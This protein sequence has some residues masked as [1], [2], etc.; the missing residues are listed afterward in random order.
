MVRIFKEFLNFQIIESGMTIGFTCFEQLPLYSAKVAHTCLFRIRDS[1]EANIWLRSQAL[2]FAK[3]CS[4]QISSRNCSY[5]HGNLLKSRGFYRLF[6]N[7][8]V[9]SFYFYFLQRL[10]SRPFCYL[11]HV[12]LKAKKLWIFKIFSLRPIL[13]ARR[14]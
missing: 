2:H 13:S 12:L 11:K 14:R 6:L 5:F 1:R 8:N 3:I 10:L 4:L 7:I 9:I